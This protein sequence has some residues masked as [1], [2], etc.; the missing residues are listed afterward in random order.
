MGA[1]VEISF[2]QIIQNLQVV[3][4]LDELLLQ[5]VQVRAAVR[6]RTPPAAPPLL[7]LASGS[8]LAASNV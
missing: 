6:Q 4:L 2:D 1:A 8:M 3:E 7:T 5:A